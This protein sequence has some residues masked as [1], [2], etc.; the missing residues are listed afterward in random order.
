M[1]ETLIQTCGYLCSYY[2]IWVVVQKIWEI[3]AMGTIYVDWFKITKQL[4]WKLSLGR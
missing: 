3:N 1:F 2:K 4:G